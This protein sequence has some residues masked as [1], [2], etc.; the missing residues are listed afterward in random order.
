MTGALATAVPAQAEP[1]PYFGWTHREDARPPGTDTLDTP[2]GSSLHLYSFDNQVTLISEGTAGDPDLGGIE[3]LPPAG[4][5]LQTGATYRVGG[6]L[7]QPT[8]SRGQVIAYRDGTMC[9]RTEDELSTG[10]SYD[11]AT[12]MVG[13]FHVDDIEYVDDN[14]VSFAATYEISCQY[15]DGPAGFEGSIAVNAPLPPAPVPDAPATPGPITDLKATNTNPDGAGTNTTTL[16]WTNPSD[17][18]D[19]TIDMVQSANASLF[20]AVLADHSTLQWRG[21]ASSYHDADVEFM[22]VRSYRVVARGTSGRLGTPSLIT[23]MG[24]RLDIPVTTRTITIGQNVPF[25]GRLSKAL[26]VDH[27]DADP[28]SGPALAGRTVVMC[29]QPTAGFVS[30]GCDPVDS[31]KTSA[32]GRFTLSATPVANSYYSVMLPSSP[33]LVGNRSFVLSTGV[34]PRTDLRAPSTQTLRTGADPR[35]SN[36]S[37]T[38]TGVR[39][40][41]IIHFTTSRA[42]RGSLGIVRLQHLRGGRWHTIVTKRLGRST[43]RLTLPVREHTR[44]LHSFRVVKPADSHHV[45]GHSHIVKIRVR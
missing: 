9:G 15:L 35:T 39:P 41:A 23:V 21:R 31:T 1:G 36:R 11:P 18:G 38:S 28:M 43:A 20:P 5:T 12:P 14:A 42:R 17:Y 30:G 44:G 19:V 26:G 8:S 2:P 24:S 37:T 6:A 25:T 32:D 4:Q 22:D 3:F 29:Q 10:G 13:W 34:A 7:R 16:T 40:G 33:D 45:N 27:A